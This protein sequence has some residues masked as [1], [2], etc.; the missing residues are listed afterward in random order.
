MRVALANGRKYPRG[1]VIQVQQSNDLKYVIGV[2]WDR[3]LPYR[4]W[5]DVSDPD[6]QIRLSHPP[7]KTSTFSAGMR[8]VLPQSAR[9]VKHGTI[10]EVAIKEGKSYIGITWDSNFPFRQWQRAENLRV[11]VFAP[12]AG[13][14]IEVDHS[15]VAMSPERT[16]QIPPPSSL[17]V[18]FV[19]KQ[20]IPNV[21]KNM[22]SSFICAAGRNYASDSNGLQFLTDDGKFLLGRFNPDSWVSAG[23]NI[24]KKAIFE[25]HARLFNFFAVLA[26]GMG[27]EQ[28]YWVEKSRMTS[29]YDIHHEHVLTPQEC[30]GSACLYVFDLSK[31]QFHWSEDDI[32]EGQ[33]D[34]REMI[35]DKVFEEKGFLSLHA[36]A[37][38]FFEPAAFK[39]ISRAT[40]VFSWSFY[41][42]LAHWRVDPLILGDLRC[43]TVHSYNSRGIDR[44]G[45][46][47]SDS[48]PLAPGAL[49]R[50]F[51]LFVGE[52]NGLFQ[53][54]ILHLTPR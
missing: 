13:Q 52:M 25:G 45:V 26:V 36:R 49:P 17:H 35:P 20:R 53:F 28:R 15:L 23:P 6:H 38:Q 2:Q 51:V 34:V 19:E 50:C 46:C 31:K 14:F 30:Q 12:R 29:G 43:D 48:S 1:T 47:H 22:R 21:P 9:V 24:W 40:S 5:I 18:T 41:S 3:S 37:F 54:F 10:A 39:K 16:E 42:R 33:I 11:A 27:S 8:V 4:D 32:D 7:Y 44:S